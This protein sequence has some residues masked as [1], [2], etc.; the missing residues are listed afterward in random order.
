MNTIK[1]AT[2]ELKRLLK[3]ASRNFSSTFTGARR[4]VWLHKGTVL[5]E[6]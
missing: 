4:S 1:N 2:E 3:M 5:K 6:M